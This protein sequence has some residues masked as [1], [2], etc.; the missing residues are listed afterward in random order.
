MTINGVLPLDASGL[1][2]LITAG[3]SGIGK[4]MARSFHERGAK[5]YICDVV[6]EFVQ[7]TLNEISGIAGTTVDVGDREAVNRMFDHAEA[8]LGGL[9]VLIN[10][11]GIAGPTANV[12]DIE[13]EALDETLRVNVEAQ[14]YCTARAVPL[15]KRAGGGSIINLSSVA[16]R[17]AFAMRTPYATA[18]WGIIGFTKSLAVEVGRE[19]IRVNAILPGHV[20]GPRFRSVVAAKAKAYGITDEEMRQEMLS[21]VATGKNVEMQDIANMALYLTSHYGAAIT[22]QAISVCGGVEMMR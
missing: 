15:L 14:F 6:D 4:V 21:F 11:A 7:E 10:N 19:N 2:V 22:G 20:N 3:G 16:G 12:E 5:V 9:D 1:R 13:T 8:T 17:L 18:K